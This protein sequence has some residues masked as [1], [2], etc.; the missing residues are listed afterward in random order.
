MTSM[1]LHENPINFN[2]RETISNQNRIINRLGVHKL[3][4]ALAKMCSRK[5]DSNFTNLEQY[6]APLDKRT[7]E[8]MN[9]LLLLYSEI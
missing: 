9:K 1:L 6:G 4:D 5:L 3:S 7:E 2:T 8:E